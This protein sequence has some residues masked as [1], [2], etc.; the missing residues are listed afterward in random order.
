[1]LKYKSNKLLNKTKQLKAFTI[2]ELLIVIVVIGIL[3][4]ITI[5][6]FGGI[7]GQANVAA[8]KSDLDSNSRKLQLYYTQYGSYPTQ[9]DANK[10]PSA[11]AADTNYCIK[12]SG[13]NI[14]SNYA[15]SNTNFTLGISNGSTC[16]QLTDTTSPTKICSSSNGY[17][18]EQLLSTATW[19]IDSAY[20]TNNQ[21]IT[22]LGT[23]GSVLNARAGSTTN[24][25]SNDPK[26]LDFDGTP[27]V[28]LPGVAGNN[29]SV[30]DA[31]N[32]D[33]TGDI[34]IRAKVALD[35]WTPASTQSF[36][37]KFETGGQNSWRFEQ[38]PS[39]LAIIWSSGGT[40][41]D[42]VI[43]AT[44]PTGIADGSAKWVRVTVDVNNGASGNDVKFYTSDDGSAWTQL[45]AT[46]TTAGVTSFFSSTS[47]V[48]VGAVTTNGQPASGKIYRAQVL[49]GING[50]TVLDV[51]TSL[52]TNGSQTS[53][54][55]LTGQTA[56]INRSTTGRK[57]VAVVSSPVWLFGT[58]DYMEVADNVLLDFGASDSFTVLA[59]VRQLATI[60]NN[61]AHISKWDGSTNGFVYR[62][63]TGNAGP[64][65]FNVGAWDGT[66]NVQPLSPTTT[67]Q[68]DLRVEGFVLN[69]SSATATAYM[70]G[71]AGTST[72]TSTFAAVTNTQVLRIGA[73][74]YASTG[75]QDFEF[76]AAAVFRRA[77][78][79]SEITTISNY[80]TARVK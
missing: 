68:Q 9:F 72:S 29:M 20:S 11:P 7:T 47:R 62:V 24:A 42:G 26:F 78:T 44:V 63:Q 21:T 30:P 28:Y 67:L 73:Y 34:D 5:V 13:S 69:R 80:Y 55:A 2:V 33:I 56:T 10:C 31:N 58:D 71:S 41:N 32:L 19:W 50:S 37:S 65:G 45:G 12:L 22:S 46:M 43:A 40:N 57:A 76:I 59:V 77:L 1:M 8:V 74:T 36:I 79:Q 75:F 18:A 4:A 15:A 52:I 54:S 23:G 17:T 66:N 35:D 70:N 6:S 48:E 64:Q 3:A 27:Y 61:G 25:D 16:Y 53:F 49:N 39:Q 51:D 14:L 60:A 38:G